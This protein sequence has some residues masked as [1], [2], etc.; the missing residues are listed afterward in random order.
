MIYHIGEALSDRFSLSHNYALLFQAYFVLYKV[1]SLMR[2]INERKVCPDLGLFH[3]YLKGF[4]I[5]LLALSSKPKAM[6]I[7][8]IAVILSGCEESSLNDYK[9]KN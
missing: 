2:C 9:A 4:Y 8:T 6:K 7:F 3:C 1:A 5:H